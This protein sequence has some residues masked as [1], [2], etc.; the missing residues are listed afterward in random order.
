VE[1]RLHGLAGTSSRELQGGPPLHTVLS[2]IEFESAS[3]AHSR[4]CSIPKA[5]DFGDHIVLLKF[6]RCG[7]PL[8]DA[9]HR[10]RELEQV[11]EV[12]AQAGHSCLLKSGASIFVYPQQY[13]SIIQVIDEQTLRPHHVIVS[14]P[15][16]PLIYCETSKLRSKDNMRPKAFPYAIVSGDDDGPIYTLEATFLSEPHQLHAPGSTTQSE[17]QA[18]RVANPRRFLLPK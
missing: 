14:E 6:S 3:S 7:K 17:S 18:H 10:G 13:K 9:L 4:T 2:D 15:F 16:L 5:S 12:A 8:M 1:R 11:R